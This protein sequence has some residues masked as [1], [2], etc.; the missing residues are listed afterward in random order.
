MS[1][2]LLPFMSYRSPS[3]PSTCVAFHVMWKDVCVCVC[4]ARRCSVMLPL[5]YIRLLRS[6]LGDGGSHRR[7]PIRWSM[8]DIGR[9]GLPDLGGMNGII[10]KPYSFT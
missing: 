8:A 1:E 9:K 7:S 2:R 6:D 3:L 4:G 5:I 10:S